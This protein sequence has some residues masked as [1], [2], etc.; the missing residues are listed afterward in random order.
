[1]TIVLPVYQRS[2]RPV[3]QQSETPCKM[4]H[5]ESIIPEKTAR[6]SGMRNMQSSLIKWFLF[7][8]PN[9]ALLAFRLSR[10]N[11]IQVLYF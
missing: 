2:K 9:S 3:Y 5:V 10:D 6:D 4:D 1:M 8:S 7:E 11:R